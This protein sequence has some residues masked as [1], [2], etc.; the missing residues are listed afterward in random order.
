MTPTTLPSTSATLDADKFLFT[1]GLGFGRD[2]WR[3]D[4]GFTYVY[5]PPVNVATA[6]A[7]VPQVAP[8]R[9][10]RDSPRY[11]INAGR[12]ELSSFVAGAG[13]NYRW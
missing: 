11:P 4:A 8:F 5:A 7:M 2:R 13:F 3:I 1:A 9:S 12:Y 6:E 10:S